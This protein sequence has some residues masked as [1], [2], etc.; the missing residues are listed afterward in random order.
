MLAISHSTMAVA[1]KA[2]AGREPKT[3]M[4]TKP[5]MTLHPTG[6]WHRLAPL[7]VEGALEHPLQGLEQ[8]PV[9][10]H[11]PAVAEHRHEPPRGE[12]EAEDAGDE[13]GDGGA[14]QAGDGADPDGEHDERSRDGEDE[15]RDRVGEQ[16]SAHAHRAE[17]DPLAALLVVVGGR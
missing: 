2:R 6:G 17:H 3:A 8:P 10:G 14:A 13:P 11:P 5:A 15:H 16:G 9:A 7:A 4:S 1:A 12:G